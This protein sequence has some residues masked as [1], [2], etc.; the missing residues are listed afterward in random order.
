MS[1]KHW[2][3]SCLCGASDY[4]TFFTYDAPPEGENLFSF[5][6]QL[7][8]RREFLRC[9]SCGHFV[10]RHQLDMSSF[11]EGSYAKSLYGGT[12]K[13]LQTYKRIMGLPEASSDNIGRV[14]KVLDLCAD[15]CSAAGAHQL[16]DVGSGLGVFIS[17]M[18]EAGWECTGLEPD[19]AYAE[20]LRVNIGATA[21]TA[22]FMVTDQLETYDLIS[23]NKVLE[24][25]SDPLTMLGRV[26]QFLKPEGCVYIE[27]PDGATASKDG[28]GREEF[29]V[30][31]YHAFSE[32]SAKYLADKAGLTI[33]HLE[34]LQEPSTKYTIRLLAQRKAA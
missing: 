17:K 18:Q 14:R 19:P 7:D 32:E 30:E 28:P 4:E 21:I 33:L 9:G 16:L 10:A 24:H 22:D 27:L 13:I 6:G 15:Y 26:H 34:S 29:F 3:D 20:H 8:Y 23:F 31:H 2:W 1:M 5:S 12:E 11:Y 25:V